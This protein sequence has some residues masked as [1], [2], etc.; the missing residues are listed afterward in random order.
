[1]YRIS[2]LSKHTKAPDLDPVCASTSKP[3]EQETPVA[4]NTDFQLKQNIEPQKTYQG[5]ICTHMSNKAQNN[6]VLGTLESVE[7]QTDCCG[8]Q[9]QVLEE[10]LDKSMRKDLIENLMETKSNDSENREAQR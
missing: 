8:A 10:D 9:I 2:G 6:P 3:E 7:T 1:M 5:C 4:N